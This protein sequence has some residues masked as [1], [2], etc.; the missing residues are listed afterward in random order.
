MVNISPP[1]PDIKSILSSAKK[2]DNLFVIL[3]RLYNA[4]FLSDCGLNVVSEMT[5]TPVLN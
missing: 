5:A 3:T 4:C 2:A 1:P